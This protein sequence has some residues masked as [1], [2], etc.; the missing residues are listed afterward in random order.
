MNEKMWS[1][2]NILFQ[3]AEKYLSEL[4]L[5]MLKLALS[6]HIFSP[7]IEMFGQ[8]ASE[9]GVPESR[10]P[11]A[12]HFNGRL[13]CNAEEFVHYFKSKGKPLFFFFENQLYR[14]D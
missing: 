14:R 11:S 2:K 12:I 4:Q 13:F 7:K 9:C 10:C 5:K 1:T 8:V 3:V 6:L